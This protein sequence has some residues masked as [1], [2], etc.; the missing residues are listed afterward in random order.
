MEI[1]KNSED[2]TLITKIHKKVIPII[3]V[4]NRSRQEN[5][6]DLHGS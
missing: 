5:I 4:L 6:W 1:A 3:P 2:L